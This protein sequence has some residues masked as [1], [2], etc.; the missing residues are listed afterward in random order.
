MLPLPGQ[1]DWF[2]QTS[3]KNLNAWRR[4]KPAGGKEYL[5]EVGNVLKDFPRMGK[6]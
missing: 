6:R 1:T 5:R 3:C 2:L 4:E